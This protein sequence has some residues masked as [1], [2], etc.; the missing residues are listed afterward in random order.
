VG[1]AAASTFDRARPGE[2]RGEIDAAWA[3]GRGAYGGLVA[4]ILA[5]ALEADAPDGHAIVT[6]TAHFCEPALAGPATVRTE[7][8]R[9]GRNVSTMR[10][11]LERGGSVLATALATLGRP[12]EGGLAHRAMEA[13]PAP[14]PDDVPDG[15]GAMYIPTFAR[16]F[17]FRQCFGPPPF[18]RGSEARVGGWCRIEE[19]GVRV[20]AA[21]VCALLDAWPPAAVALSP[22]WCP[23]A[24]IDL[25][26]HV[27]AR[28]PLASASARPWLLYDARARHV[29]GG[30]ADEVATL[31][32]EDGTPIATARQLVAVFPPEPRR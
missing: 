21:L 20:D 32:A 24:S 4:A 12:R 5:R 31:F 18:E 11:S 17:A 23:V 28:L 15:P 6:L 26:V 7:V 3:Q 13:P 1:F 19:D 22:S 16:Y 10:A 30:L 25:T 27:L 2:H 29:G 9:A 8:V 14:P